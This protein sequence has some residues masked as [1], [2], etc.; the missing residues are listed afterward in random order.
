M[1]RCVQRILSLSLPPGCVLGGADMGTRSVWL[2]SREVS[3]RA[4]VEASVVNC[5]ANAVKVSETLMNLTLLQHFYLKKCLI[6]RHLSRNER[7]HQV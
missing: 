2:L 4:R 3:S 1:I 6:L 5:P 7:A